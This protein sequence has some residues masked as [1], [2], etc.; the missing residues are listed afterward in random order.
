MVEYLM[1]DR[2]LIE[3]RHLIGAFPSV[4]SASVTLM[5]LNLMVIVILAVELLNR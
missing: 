3:P 1:E 4:D 2:R 5:D